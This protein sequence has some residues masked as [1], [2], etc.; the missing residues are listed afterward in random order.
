M[1]S[2]VSELG[3]GESGRSTQIWTYFVP[4]FCYV[5]PTMDMLYVQRETHVHTIGGTT[6]MRTLVRRR[7]RS[8]ARSLRDK[9]RERT[10]KSL[11]E[12]CV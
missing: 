11:P 5:K 8:E 4:F 10:K 3:E 1:P 6:R 2:Q 7:E 9:E 12:P